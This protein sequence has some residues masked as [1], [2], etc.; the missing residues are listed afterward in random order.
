[1][2]HVAN[3]Y[4]CQV[5]THSRYANPTHQPRQVLTMITGIVPAQAYNKFSQQA[6]LTYAR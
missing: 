4:F 6:T 1:M 3:S 2:R 5:L